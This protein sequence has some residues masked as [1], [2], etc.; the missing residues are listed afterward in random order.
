MIHGIHTLGVLGGVRIFDGE[1]DSRHNF[2]RLAEF[3]GSIDVVG[4]SAFQCAFEVAVLNGEVECPNVM[5]NDLYKLVIKS[6]QTP[7]S[8]QNHQIATP[9]TSSEKI[10]QIIDLIKIAKSTAL[11]AKQRTLETLRLAVQNVSLDSNELIAELSAIA[12]QNQKFPGDNI[13]RMLTLIENAT[14]SSNS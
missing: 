2:E 8:G 13:N 10:Y 14:K 1:P 3:A 11:D 4:N 7:S 12:W 6:G 5:L 9:D